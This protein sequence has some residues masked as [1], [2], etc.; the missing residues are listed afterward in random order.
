MPWDGTTLHVGALDG[1]GIAGSVVVAGSRTESVVEPAWDRDGTLY[2]ISDRSGWWN[3]Q[4]WD[5][6]R[7]RPVVALKSE[8]ASPLWRLGQANYALTGDGRA[9]ARF[10]EE[11]VDRL[12]VVDL[13][14]GRLD[15]LPLPFTSYSGI[16]LLN[17]GE[18]VAIAAS[19]SELHAVVAIDLASRKHRTL[20]TPN[21]QR[22]DTALLSMPEK[23]AFPT[24]GGLTA[25]AFYYSPVNPAFEAPP[26]TRPPLLVKFHGGPTSHSRPILD[27]ALQYWTSRG[28]AVVDVNYRGSS[29]FGRVY[30]RRLHGNWG[31]VDVE[32]A[33]A[34]VRY[35]VKQGRV[36]PDRIAIRGG[37]AGGF[38]TLAALAFTDVFRAGANYYGVSD[39]EA[40]ARDT[41][42]F[43]S[44]YLDSIV[45]PLPAGKAVYD[46]RSPIL[47]LE[48]FN[49]PL[50]TFQGLEDRVVPPSQS[51]LIVQALERKGVPA[52]YLEFAG[53]QHGFRR[54]QS[55]QR[56]AEAELYF[57]GRIF[58]FS[59]AD[60]LQPVEIRNLP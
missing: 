9:V 5:G 36:D 30:R 51:R 10:G 15:V 55:I 52:A 59:P 57:Y 39:L 41:H 56:A 60:T 1:D 49:E 50:I 19:G 17:D 58:G 48:G 47:H 44:R 43:E 14:S 45:A 22:L 54:A 37:S 7:V 31:I 20:R 32:D 8:F 27:L 21:D 11:A 34:A 29:D 18:A 26:G 28:F 16:Q 35:L 24:D 13:K 46:A 53:E 40:L 4:R 33:V 42:K 2:F 25:H 23:I 6:R 38:T 12:A 3:L